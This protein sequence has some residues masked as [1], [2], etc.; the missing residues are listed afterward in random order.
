MNRNYVR[1]YSPWHFTASLLIAFAIVAHTPLLAIGKFQEQSGSSVLDKKEE[2]PSP[3]KPAETKPEKPDPVAVEF[4]ALID[5]VGESMQAFHKELQAA[6]LAEQSKLKLEKKPANKFAGDFHSF[7]DKHKDHATAFDA[8]SFLVINCTGATKTKAI[9]RLI[10]VY[11]DDPRTIRCMQAITTGATT[12]EPEKWL[13][14]LQK[15]SKNKEVRGNAMKTQID[16]IRSV[17]QMKNIIDDQ[18]DLK[19]SI[20]KEVVEFIGKYDFDAAEKREA[21]LL[22]TL[23]DDYMDVPSSVRGKTLGQLAKLDIYARDRLS[24][25]GQ[26]PDMAGINLDSKR[27][28][29][30][31]FRPKV[32][33]LVF[34]GNW[35]RESQALYPQLRALGKILKDKPFQ[36]VGVNSDTNRKLLRSTISTVQLDWPNYWDRSARGEIS[37]RWLIKRWPTTF[38]LDS[39]GKIQHIGLTGK[40]L[41]KAVIEMMKELGHEVEIENYDAGKLLSPTPLA[42]PPTDDDT[43]PADGGSKPEDGSSKSKIKTSRP[44]ELTG[45]SIKKRCEFSQRFLFINLLAVRYS[46]IVHCA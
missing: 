45:Q 25:G 31:E 23:A 43:K 7:A 33:L 37:K 29:L 35:S 38:L 1:A 8:I 13:E 20:D 42:K 9:D 24:I 12:P 46:M 4:Q 32:V 16:Y 26:A 39:K 28:Q 18:P 22:D 40:E 6:P 41:D 34:W 15:E 30:S 21:K 36:I 3:E 5:K 17:K 27:M 44:T 19:K 10:K 14:Q 2:D 11:A